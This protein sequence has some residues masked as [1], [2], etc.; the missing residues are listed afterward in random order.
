MNRDTFAGQWKQ[1]KG[2]IKQRWAR[3]TDDDL[4]AVEGS[5][6]R[7]VGTVQE[8]YGYGRDRAEAE[9]DDWLQA[10]SDAE[11]LKQAR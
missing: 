6:D 2:G 11:V 1:L 4:L 7:L 3:L 9:I 10:E 5:F 8:R